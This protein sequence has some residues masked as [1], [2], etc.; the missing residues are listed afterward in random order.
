MPA[1]DGRGQH[2]MGP[3]SAHLGGYLRVRAESLDDARRFLAGNPVYESGGTYVE[4]D[5]VFTANTTHEW[6]HG[7]GEIVSA[8]HAEGMQITG[9]VLFVMG[10]TTTHDAEVPIYAFGDPSDP[11]TARLGMTLSPTAGGAYATL[12]LH[13][14]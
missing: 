10:M 4:T 2:R 7:L 1:H 8:L 13:A 9:L 12:A 6:N 11:R 5:V 3:V 14:M